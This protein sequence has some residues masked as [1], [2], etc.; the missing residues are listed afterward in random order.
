VVQENRDR[1]AADEA[2]KAKLQ[3]AL[4]RLGA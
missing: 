2:E 4:A 3:E 1:I